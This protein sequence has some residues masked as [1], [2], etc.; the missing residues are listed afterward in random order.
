MV[1]VWRRL[2]GQPMSSDS[3][4]VTEAKLQEKSLPRD[5]VTGSCIICMDQALAVV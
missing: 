2:N 4:L 1:T 3:E 5:V